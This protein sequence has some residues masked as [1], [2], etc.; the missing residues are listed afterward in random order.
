MLDVSGFGE[1][2]DARI[3]LKTESAVD[4]AVGSWNILLRKNLPPKATKRIGFEWGVEQWTPLT[5]LTYAQAHC[6]DRSSS[7]NGLHY[8]I[9]AN[10]IHV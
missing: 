7:G 3:H 8:A 2:F 4:L 10:P 5:Y 9:H 6:Y 1:D